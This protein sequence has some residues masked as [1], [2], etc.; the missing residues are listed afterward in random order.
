LIDE[1][2]I[3]G[4]ASVAEHMLLNDEVFF[5]DSKS[6]VQRPKACACLSMMQSGMRCLGESSYE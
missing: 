4:E 6:E 3:L 5:F 2:T 1:N